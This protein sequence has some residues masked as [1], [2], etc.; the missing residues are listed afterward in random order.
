VDSDRRR[1]L[2][3]AKTRA[4]VR[5]QFGAAP[6]GSVP[7]G[8]G[9][10]M[11][12]HTSA[13]V[14]AADDESRQLGRALALAAA[15]DLTD[16]HVLVDADGADLAR[17]GAAL[18]PPAHVWRVEG[19]ALVPVEPAPLP[20]EAPPPADA[21]AADLARVLAGA[22]V[23]IVVEHGVISGEVRGLEVARV[24]RNDDGRWVLDVGVG[25]FDQEA[26][27]VLHGD[28]PTEVA[29]ERAV[30]YVR[31]HRRPGAAP[32]PV[33]RLARDRWLRSQLLADSSPVE[34]VDLHAVSTAT[35]RP[36]VRDPFPAPAVGRDPAGARV[37]VVCSVGVDLDLVP[38]TADLILREHPDRVVLVTPG[39]DQLPVQRALAERLAVPAD[40]VAVEGAWPH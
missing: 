28:L 8:T 15:R 5:E 7:V 23:D 31:E 35:P 39:R 9:A 4:L 21:E 12:D 40:L 34:L 36:N 20:E 33:N 38:T 24:R 30:A 14:Y 17:R 26:T 16:V 18:A 29:L 13:W 1:A 32:H 3:E 27:S 6:T 22:E 10:A 37:L 11:F 19:T 25:R 2:Y